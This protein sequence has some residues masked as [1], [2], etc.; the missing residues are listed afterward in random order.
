[1]SAI[2]GVDVGSTTM[3]GGLVTAE[4]EIL[5]AVQIPTHRDG[6][7]SAL[8]TLVE[9]VGGL[10]TEARGREIALLGVGV[11]LPGLVDGGK[12]IMRSS[13]NHVPEFHGVPLAD[14]L[15]AQTGLPAFVDN[16][17][18]ALALAEWAFGLR[19]GARSL[20][21][22]AIGTGIGGGI[23]LNSEL[24][25]GPS[26]YAGELGHMTVNFRG[27]L[28]GVCGSRG[29]MAAYLDGVQI[30]AQ[31]RALMTAR[32]GG[33]EPGLITAPMVFEAAAVGDRLAARIVDE[34]CEALAAGLGAIVNALNPQVL[35]V[36]GGVATS[37]A[38]LEA[39]IVRRVASYALEAAL[40]ET[41]IAIVP[42]DKRTTARG[43]AALVLYELARRE[44]LVATRSDLH[45]AR[46]G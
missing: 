12:G 10:L 2:I 11:G 18:N 25:R 26:G 7:G 28:C 34:A 3:S 9:I 33:S 13:A 4:G 22:L 46:E 1:M 31:A 44:H 35:V 32:A 5:T 42:S 45:E 17:V 39:D 36:T 30:A 40:E 23:I 14:R 38:P 21:L 8:D 15:A 19:R 37:L 24:V 6:R 29:C 20:V 16:D 27:P 41:R 43:G